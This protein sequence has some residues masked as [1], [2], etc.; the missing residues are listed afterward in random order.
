MK[1]AKSDSKPIEITDLLSTS[2]TIPTGLTRGSIRLVPCFLFELAVKFFDPIFCPES[3]R[4]NLC[5]SSYCKLTFGTY[6]TDFNL[7]S[8]FTP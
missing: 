3:G 5:H 4:L 2:R 1:R 8:S 6:F 7:G